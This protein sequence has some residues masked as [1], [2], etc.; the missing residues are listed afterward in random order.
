[1][2]LT[3]EM[4]KEL[5]KAGL[6]GFTIH[7]DSHQNRP[8][9]KGKTEK[10]LNELRQQ[11]AEMIH[12]EGGLYVVFNST[13]YPST[14]HEIPDVV[15]WGREN[16]DK[17]H[18]LVFITYRTGT[19]DTSVAVAVD[20]KIVD[21]SKLSYVREHFEENFVTSPE[22]YQII[23]DNNPEYDAGCYLG[24]TLRHRVVQVAGRRLDR[25]EEED[26]RLGG[27]ADHGSGPGRPPPALKGT[28]LAYLSDAKIGAKVFLLSAMGPALSAGPG[29]SLAQE[30]AA[31]SRPAV[32]LDLRAEHRH[33][34]GAGHSA[35]RPRRHVRQLP[36]HD[37]VGRQVRQLLPHGRVPPVRRVH[38]SV[39]DKAKVAQETVMADQP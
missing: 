38:V 2:A 11:Y 35:R 34:P 25:H 7:I 3:P 17:V 1:M 5:K 39:L 28:Y 12:D 16:I 18:G 20:S 13:V 37:G 8:H 31:A 24:G 33:H 14:Y 29:Q 9:W 4:L 19:A 27:Q 30:R 22:V 21:F 23:Q 26:V 32:R 15:R 6:S 10:D 36:G